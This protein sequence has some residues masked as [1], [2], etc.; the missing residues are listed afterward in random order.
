M[1]YLVRH[2]DDG[3]KRLWTGPEEDR[4]LSATGRLEAEGLIALLAGYPI[5]E[6]VSSPALRCSQTVEPL[7]GQ[8]RL[9]VRTDAAL[10][11]DAD[12]DRAVALV[13]DS[14]TD[15]AVLCTHGELIRP[16][17]AR[18]RELGAPLGDELAWPKGS[19]WALEAVDG[20]IT[21]ATYLPPRQV[22]E[23]R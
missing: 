12:P 16:V 9:V 8:R 13:L 19:V 15:G 20:T 7:A 10:S 18:L 2:G 14:S 4:P 1:R 3:D 11:V 22:D 5:H 21:K 23:S 6:I 17:L